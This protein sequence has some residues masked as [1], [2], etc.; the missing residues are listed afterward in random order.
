MIAQPGTMNLLPPR[1]YCAPL[2]EFQ[3]AHDR[4]A[5]VMSKLNPVETNII[6][7]YNELEQRR[8]L[9]DQG[10]QLYPDDEDDEPFSEEIVDADLQKAAE[11][12]NFLKSLNPSDDATKGLFQGSKH[13]VAALGTIEKG[14]NFLETS[15]CKGLIKSREERLKVGGSPVS[16]V[17]AK[18]YLSETIA[19]KDMVQAMIVLDMT[20]PT[21]DEVSAGMTVKD[22]LN[23]ASFFIHGGPKGA[24]LA[25]RNLEELDCTER[26]R[27]MC[28]KFLEIWK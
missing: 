16:L 14:A 21:V 13:V 8:A 9:L 1:R 10:A 28:T 27:S 17:N 23:V 26:V 19:F 15:R 18:I 5:E 24:M 20:A 25:W 7:Y 12:P 11:F 3:V 2:D 4:A 6:D 22:S